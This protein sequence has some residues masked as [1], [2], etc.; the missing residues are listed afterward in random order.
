MIDFKEKIESLQKWDVG[1]SILRITSAKK[2][3]NFLI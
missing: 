2:K 1:N 3:L